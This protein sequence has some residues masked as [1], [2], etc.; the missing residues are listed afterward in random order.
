[1]EKNESTSDIIVTVTTYDSSGEFDTMDILI[2]GRKFY[3]VDT[4]ILCE[5]GR[6]EIRYLEYSYNDG[7]VFSFHDHINGEDVYIVADRIINKTELTKPTIIISK[8][9]TKDYM[10]KT[11]FPILHKTCF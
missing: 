7:K 5:Y 10:K 2:S 6:V 11:F 3:G 1:M 9:D 4:D 8:V